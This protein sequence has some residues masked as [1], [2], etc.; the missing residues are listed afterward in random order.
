MALRICMPLSQKDAGLIAANVDLFRALG[1][2]PRHHL[3]LCP[4][5]SVIP[6]AHQAAERLKAWAQSVEVIE[7]NDENYRTW[8]MAG[9]LMWQHCAEEIIKKFM[10]GDQTP[11]LYMEP[12]C[13][14]L[15]EGWADKLEAEYALSGCK[16]MG[17]QMPSRV[18]TDKDKFTTARFIPGQSAENIPFM[19]SPAIFP[20]DINTLTGGCWRMPRGDA[21]DKMLKFYW[22]RSLC[23]TKLIQHQWR[24]INYREMDGKII[25]DDSTE[26][27]E[28]QYNEAGE[29]SN[30]AVF[31]HGC[32]DG[33]LARIIRGRCKALPSPPEPV[34]AIVQPKQT[35]PQAPAPAYGK[36]TY[37]QAGWSVV[38]GSL[39]RIAGQGQP[40]PVHA[41]PPKSEVPPLQFEPEEVSKFAEL[42]Q[43]PAPPKIKKKAGRPRKV[44]AIV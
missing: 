30:E 24:T 20:A 26:N 43:P 25:C 6:H 12:D 44:P 27:I 15:C 35:L 17:T 1:G 19:P 29:V 36:V 3:M 18:Y 10:R 37:D 39:D 42:K 40:T 28:Q 21:W 4:T 16:C 22:N 14:P 9:N 13:T 31:H 11:W 38:Q 41:E 23:I 5:R 2:A 34:V 32:K 33:S 8:P 7:W